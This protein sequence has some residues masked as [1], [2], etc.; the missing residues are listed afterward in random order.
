MEIDGRL[1]ARLLGTLPARLSGSGAV[2]ALFTPGEIVQARV[3]SRIDSQLLL[4]EIKGHEL[5]ARNLV[6]LKPGQVV[7]VEVG[8]AS[9]KA[10]GGG[11]EV[12]LHLLSQPG[13]EL[14]LIRLL[15]EAL[16]DSKPIN[17]ALT[18]LAQTLKELPTR[19]QSPLEAE[20]R[21]VL[22]ALRRTGLQ[23]GAD[24]ASRVRELPARLGLDL[25]PVLGRGVASGRLE[26]AVRDSL[27]LGLKPRLIALVRQLEP[28]VAGRQDMAVSFPALAEVAGRLAARL[29]QGAGS[30]PAPQARGLAQA[31]TALL[32]EAE[33]TLNRLL[34]L[35]TEAGP[36]PSK[37]EVR[38][39][40]QEIIKRS[41]PGLMTATKKAPARTTARPEALPP[42]KL[43][44][45][46]PAGTLRPEPP[47][48]TA[49]EEASTRT[50]RPEAAP[51]SAPPTRGERGGTLPAA[52]FPARSPGASPNPNPALTAAVEELE[53]ALTNLALRLGLTPQALARAALAQTEGAVQSL[54]SVQLLNLAASETQTAFIIPLIAPMALGL[55]AARFHLFKPPAGQEGEGEQPL[56]LVFLLEMTRI[57]PVRVDLS[58][59]RKRVM[60]N[61]YTTE[62]RTASFARKRIDKLSE[63][64]TK[65]GYQVGAVNAGLL[66]AAPPIES[67]APPPYPVLSRSLI[68]LRA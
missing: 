10:E 7:E 62:E 58:L 23:P 61:L 31:Q 45:R 4:L 47:S 15:K 65:L 68:D 39:R 44:A 20:T 11:E 59:A 63:S 57:G 54:E 17:P 67:L 8:P 24:L 66:K 43:S 64:L 53:Q 56:R 32:E 2:E 42:T 37:E 30:K 18:R 36:R 40:L 33:G 3:L 13:K 26:P 50:L 1:L 16:P 34:A 5:V 41:W 19:P 35:G 60:I 27:L 6:G 55:K 46:P 49:I 51:E 48:A 22:S 14:P 21:A 29:A 38:A 28:A 9:A 25:E 52:E 12:V